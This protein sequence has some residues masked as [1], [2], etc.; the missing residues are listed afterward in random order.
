MKRLPKFLK[1]YF[2]EIDFKRLDAD[3]YPRYVIERILDYGDESALRWL[4]KNFALSEVRKVVCQTRALSMRSVYFWV[5]VLGVDKKK[6]RC[7]SKDF[8]KIYRAIW[9]Y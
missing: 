3:K 2:W 7:L 8:Q 5:T 1:P 4:G 6:V 9:P